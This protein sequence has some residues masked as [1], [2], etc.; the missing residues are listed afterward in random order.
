MPLAG[1]ARE[2]TFRRVVF[3]SPQSPRGIGVEIAR[4]GHSPGLGRAALA[5]HHA[6][7]SAV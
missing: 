5:A 7:L 6:G 3:A 2:D 4:T 1:F